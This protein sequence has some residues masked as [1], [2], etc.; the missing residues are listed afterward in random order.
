MVVQNNKPES[1]ENEEC[2]A[3]ERQVKQTKQAYDKLMKS[4]RHLKTL[5]KEDLQQQKLIHM[6]K[7]NYVPDI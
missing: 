5:G 7:C 4:K 6:I 2:I 1:P 3:N